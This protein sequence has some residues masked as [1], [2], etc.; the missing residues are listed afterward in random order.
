[1]SLLQQ[2]QESVIQ[3]SSDLG[4]I[5]LK[6]RLLA[7]RLGSDILEEWVKYESEGYPVESEV[8]AYRVA[9]VSYRGTFSGAFGASINN[10][11]IPPYIIEQYA[12][13]S[14][15][16]YEVRESVAAVS[17]MVRQSSDGASFGINAWL[18]CVI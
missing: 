13:K 10:A 16:K 6:L 5:L 14:W 18:C 11:Q 17:D 9:E 1:M 2:I 4:S 15:T 7:A 12:G 8:P 3:E